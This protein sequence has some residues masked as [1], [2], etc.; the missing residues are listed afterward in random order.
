MKLRSPAQLARALQLRAA[1]LAELPLVSS[2]GCPHPHRTES[3]ALTGLLQTQMYMCGG[4]GPVL[5]P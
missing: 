5:T 2:S 1:T 3:F 4:L